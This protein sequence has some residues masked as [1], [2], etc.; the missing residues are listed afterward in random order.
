MDINSISVNMDASPTFEIQS[1]IEAIHT[2]TTDYSEILRR[3]AGIYVASIPCF[4]VCIALEFAF[5]IITLA[6]GSSNISACPIESRIPIYL[7]VSSV[8]NL[9]SIFLSTTACALHIKEKDKDMI[10]FFCVFF[11]AIGIIILQ[12]FL[13]IW[14]IIGTMWV[15]RNFNQ[16]EYNSLTNPSNYCQPGLYQYSVITIVLQ[17]ITPLISCCC[18]NFAFRKQTQ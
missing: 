18:K 13:F 7:V 14:L 5:T 2:E 12:L 9:V 16:V 1:P 3:I 17:Y 8:V 11:S 15:F 10:G 6:V 4:I